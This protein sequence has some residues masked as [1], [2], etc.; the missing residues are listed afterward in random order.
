MG[1][2]LVFYHSNS[3]N[4]QHM[5][6]LVGEGAG[7][8][9]DM[10]VRVLSTQ[11]AKAS[12]LEWCD[13]IAVGSPTN[14]GTVAWEMKRWWD[15]EA[16]DSWM[17]VDG[18][19]ACA[20][21]TQGGWGGGG[22]H[23]SGAFHHSDQLWIPRLWCHRLCRQAGHPPLRCDLRR[24]ARAD[25]EQESCRRLGRR[26]AEWVACFVDGRQEFHPKLSRYH[27]AP[28]DFS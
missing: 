16:Y 3:G 4:T 18:R 28:E 5:A 20:F 25:W 21:A 7:S 24:R 2:I 14:F 17:R 8:I 9:P 27:R 12:D 10:E 11:E 23:L 1:R 26:L 19:F 15:T 6:A 22:A 13:G